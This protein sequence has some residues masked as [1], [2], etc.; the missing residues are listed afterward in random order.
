MRI[1]RIQSA[2]KRSKRAG[3]G[4][5]LTEAIVAAMIFIPVTLFILDLTV[6]VLA[7]SKNDQAAKSAARAA[8]NQPD[9]AQADQAAWKALQSFK[10]SSIVKSVTFNCVYTADMVT[11]KTRMTVKLPIPFPGFNTMVFQAQAREPVVGAP[12]KE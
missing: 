6:I 5:S 3:R 1:S 9:Q 10:T 4:T 7:N 2:T 11:C 8:A 12:A